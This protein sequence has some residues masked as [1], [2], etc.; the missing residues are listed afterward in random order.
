MPKTVERLKAAQTALKEALTDKDM[1]EPKRKQLQSGYDQVQKL[2]EEAMKCAAKEESGKEEEESK[3]EAD[4][5]PPHAGLKPGHKVTKTTTIAH[6]GPKEEEEEEEEESAADDSK[7]GDGDNDDDGDSQ[8]SKRG[9]L[10]SLLKEA[11]IPQKLW[12]LDKLMKLSLKE[13]KAE[14][15]EKKALVESIREEREL[16]ETPVDA[17]GAPLHE[18]GDDARGTLNGIFAGCANG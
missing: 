15:E 7:D 12:A 14:I 13:A 5:Q 10:K 17:G 18:S 2:L 1:A 4:D 8:E 3:E 6:E 9:Y 16:Q 11:G